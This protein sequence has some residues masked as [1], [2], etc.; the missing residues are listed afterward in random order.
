MSR[1]LE[2]RL[3]CL[4]ERV[5]PPVP[6]ETL[7]IYFVSA[8]GKVTGTRI[9]V[10]PQCPPLADDNG[11]Q[12]PRDVLRGDVAQK[13][14]QRESQRDAWPFDAQESRETKDIRA[15]TSRDR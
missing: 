10:F 3:V 8:K 1:T 7:E 13:F 15:M 4:E 14:A 12:Q 2:R 5:P 6:P 9:F 11:E